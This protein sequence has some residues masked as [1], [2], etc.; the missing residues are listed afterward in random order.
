V[1]VRST[2]QRRRAILR[3]LRGDQGVA[4]AEFA[5]LAVVIL[6]LTFIA[7][8]VG[9]Y[10]HAR[11]VAQSAARHGVEAARAQGATPADG[12]S[13]A[14]DF[15]NRYGDSVQGPHVSTTGSTAQT[16]R[17]TIT[18]HVATLVP[19]LE[20]DVTQHAQAPVERWTTP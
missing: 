4:S 6:A 9:F 13:Q 12:I 19:G 20:L 8:Q 1:T 11:K 3:R 15:L 2:R 10:Y 5:V 16:I 18:G 17:I 14:R 7:I